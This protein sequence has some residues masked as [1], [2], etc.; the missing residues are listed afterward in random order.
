MISNYRRNPEF[1]SAMNFNINKLEIVIDLDMTLIHCINP[2]C[3][4]NRRAMEEELEKM[5]RELPAI[6]E[7]LHLIDF[8]SQGRA[9]FMIMA[10]RPFVERY[11]NS[12]NMIGNLH[13]YTSASRDYAIRILKEIDPGNRLFGNRIY[14]QENPSSDTPKTMNRYLEER[15]G[16]VV[17]LDDQPRVWF[18]GH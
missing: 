17:V 9:H 15:H 10:K 4:N 2:S 16:L 5:K 6:A 11:L 12:L 1:I 13:L 3:G 7:N 8:S 14:A 18:H